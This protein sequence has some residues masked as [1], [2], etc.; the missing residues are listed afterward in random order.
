MTSPL[1][2]DTHCLLWWLAQPEQLSATAL[3]AISSTNAEIFVSAATGWEI[4][5]KA[6]LGKLTIPAD[7]TAEFPLVLQTQG[8]SPLPIQLNHALRAGG[9]PQHHRDPF[10]RMLAAQAELEGLTLL[11]NDPELRAFPCEL[12]W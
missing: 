9:Y 7:I 3:Q 5:T 12:L 11:S 1:L 8:F 10:D 2:L 6:R 4:A